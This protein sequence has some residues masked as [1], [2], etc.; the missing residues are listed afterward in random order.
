LPEVVLVRPLYISTGIQS[1]NAWT[2]SNHK[3]VRVTYTTATRTRQIKKTTTPQS[4]DAEST[5]N[6]GLWCPWQDNVD[7]VTVMAMQM[8][9]TRD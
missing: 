5:N 4:S 3:N 9:A 6:R 8:Q 7:T 1:A 2:G